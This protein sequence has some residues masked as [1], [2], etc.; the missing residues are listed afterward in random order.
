LCDYNYSGRLALTTTNTCP[1]LLVS[2]KAIAV[3]ATSNFKPS[4]TALLYIPFYCN[5]NLCKQQLTYDDIYVFG[6]LNITV[7]LK[8]K[9]GPAG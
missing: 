9:H 6:C 4:K 8:L 2:L 1:H 7:V 3:L 5:E